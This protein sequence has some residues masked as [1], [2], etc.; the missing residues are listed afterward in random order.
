MK[1]V[2]VKLESAS[3]QSMERAI[4]NVKKERKLVL[5][6]LLI[7]LLG[8]FSCHAYWAIMDIPDQGD[9]LVSL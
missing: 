5:S 7:F 1:L 4:S 2:K 9:R 3:Y 8:T 6:A